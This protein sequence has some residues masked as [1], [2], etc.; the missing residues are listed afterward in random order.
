MNFIYISDLSPD[1]RF[2]ELTLKEVADFIGER[3]QD[4]DWNYLRKSELREERSEGNSNKQSD[5]SLSEVC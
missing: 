3:L 5:R 4:E 1:D 2:V